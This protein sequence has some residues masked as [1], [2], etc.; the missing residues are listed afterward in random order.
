MCVQGLASLPLRS[1]VWSKGT[2]PIQ[3]SR[4]CHFLVDLNYSS[5]K[6]HVALKLSYSPG[7]RDLT[8]VEINGIAWV[9]G[10]RV[11]IPNFVSLKDVIGF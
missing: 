3:C 8:R 6:N 11:H 7:T 10:A 9:G 2:P 1:S 5:T 4:G